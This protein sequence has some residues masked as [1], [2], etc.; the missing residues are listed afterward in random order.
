MSMKLL[1]LAAAIT[2]GQFAN[3]MILP[4]LPRLAHD[5][6]LPAAQ[7]G[8]VVTVYFA[9]FAAAGLVAGTFS[10]RVG[11]RPLL[12]GG[13]VLLAIGS[14]ACAFAASLAMLLVYRLIEAAGAAGT[15]VLARAIVRDTRRGDRLAAALGMLAMIMSVSSVF[16]PILGGIA[17]DTLGWRWIFGILAGAAAL[18]ALAVSVFIAETL[19]P[20][21]PDSASSTL[22]HMRQLLVLDHFRRGVVFGAAFY[23]GFGALYTNAPFVLIDHFGLGHSQFG[24]AFAIISA[25]VAVGGIVGPRLAALPSRVSLLDAASAVATVSGLLLYG[26]TATGQENVVTIVSCLALFG[27]AFGVALSVGAALTF[28]DAGEAA[29]SA[30]SLSGFLQVGAA[31]LGSAVANLFHTGSTMPVSIILLA[32]GVVAFLAVRGLDLATVTRQ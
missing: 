22:R 15:P 11:R 17:V 4:A 20:R 31:A 12:I 24:A 30:S 8:L 10:D 6:G 26:F 25:G 32:V 3:T 9:G 1:L 27:L 21:T 7:A 19:P 13:I 5:M 23:F 29:G 18:A 2:I 28:S 16:G 14:L